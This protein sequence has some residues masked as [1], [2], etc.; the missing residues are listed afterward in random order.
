MFARSMINLFVPIYLLELGYSWTITFLFMTIFSLSHT[1]MSLVSAKISGKIGYKHLILI[2]SPI[3]IVYYL[4]LNSINFIA[5]LNIPILLI[6]IFG[7]VSNAMFWIGYHTDFAE[8]V[9]NKNSGKNLGFV[10]ILTSICQSF[11]PLVGAFLLSK[12]NFGFVFIIVSILIGLSTIPLLFRKDKHEKFNVKFKDI[13]KLF[14]WR[15]I[16]A[17]MGFGIESS[18]YFVVWPIY[19]YYFILNEGLTKLG[20]ITSLSLIFSLIIT[21]F[22]TKYVDKNVNIYYKISTF[23]SAGIWIIKNFIRTYLGVF[24]V[25]SIIGLSK[26]T[27]NIT[28]NKICYDKAKKSKKTLAYITI[29]EMLINGAHAITYFAIIFIP[30]FNIMFFLATIGS[31][32]FLFYG[33]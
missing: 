2:S 8:S 26:S 27:Q 1:I 11:G 7:G 6:A 22:M 21:Y 3:M 13:N 10:K 31:L 16:I 30:N 24:I 5:S 9:K 28:F 12:L 20:S 14:S 29:R 4:L 18:M 17:H 32:M 19:I 15:A 25:D 23:V 33:E